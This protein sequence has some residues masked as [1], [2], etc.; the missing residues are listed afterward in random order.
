[1]RKLSEILD[2]EGARGAGSVMAADEKSENLVGDVRLIH[3]PAVIGAREQHVGQ[4]VLRRAGL[5]FRQLHLPPLDDLQQLLSYELRRLYG[6]VELR[7]GNVDRHRDDPGGQHLEGIL[8]LLNLRRVFEAHKQPRRQPEGVLLRQRECQDLALFTVPIDRK[9][10]LRDGIHDS[11]VAV[12]G[13]RLHEVWEELPQLL[14]LRLGGHLPGGRE[15][16]VDRAGPPRGDQLVL[17]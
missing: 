9:V 2:D 8:K 4:D 5:P 7:P 14:G 15:H 10:A 11:D 3:V 13:L 16:L 1:M 12:Q 6:P 17:V